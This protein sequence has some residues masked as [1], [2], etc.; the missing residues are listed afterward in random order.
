[1]AFA[2]RYVELRSFASKFCPTVERTVKISPV[3]EPE[4]AALK[5]TFSDH[6]VYAGVWGQWLICRAL[7]RLGQLAQDTRGPL[8]TLAG[9]YS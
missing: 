7:H 2:A 5:R 1:M 9:C 4:F 3:G 6:Y 8:I